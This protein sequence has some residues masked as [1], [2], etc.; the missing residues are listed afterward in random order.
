MNE[1][2]PKSVSDRFT[3][4]QS[5][6]KCNS[7]SPTIQPTSTKFS[8]FEPE[9]AIFET[10]SIDR[11]DKEQDLIS[12]IRSGLSVDKDKS[13]R[14]LSATKSRNNS[15]TPRGTNKGNKPPK[16]PSSATRPDANNLMYSP[17]QSDVED[18]NFEDF[19]RGILDTP[20]AEMPDFESKIDQVIKH[21]DAINID[22]LSNNNFNH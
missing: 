16:H 10:T 22:V 3:S 20:Y 18:I 14:D 9:N 5:S 19:K 12:Q 1:P 13:D 7:K 8:L 11:D 4:P 17:D 21:N 2:D 15:T 6:N